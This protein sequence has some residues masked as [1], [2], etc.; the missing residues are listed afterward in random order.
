MEQV[1]IDFY[2]RCDDGSLPRD[3]ALYHWYHLL[4]EATDT[5]CKPLAYNTHTRQMLQ[6]AGFTEVDEQ[7]IRMPYHPWPLDKHEKAIGMWCLLGL[8]DSEYLE[9]L[10]Y[11]P[12]SRVLRW[13]KTKID[14]LLADVTKEILMKK[15]H[16]YN[17]MHIWTG[18]RPA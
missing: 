13:D 11:G 2:P 7:V 8:T 18:R 17:E 3:S 12:F 14:K 1:E 5:A 10:S 4:M 9:A 6:Q 15:Y 16:V